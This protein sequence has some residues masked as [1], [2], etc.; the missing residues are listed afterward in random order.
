[1]SV[2]H[3]MYSD[4][5]IEVMSKALQRWW[6]ASGSGG[7]ASLPATEVFTTSFTNTDG[8]LHSPSHEDILDFIKLMDKYSETSKEGSK[9]ES[10]KVA[11]MEKVGT[12][13]ELAE[14]ITKNAHAAANSAVLTVGAPEQVSAVKSDGGK[15]VAHCIGGERFKLIGAAVKSKKSPAITL[16][17]RPVDAAHYAM[18]EMSEGNYRRIFGTQGIAVLDACVG[19][20]YKAAVSEIKSVKSK[21]K[22]VL[23]LKEKQ[24]VYKDIGYGSW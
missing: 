24:D 11:N 13:K 16:L 14:L 18:I 2:T 12:Y 7:G 23:A 10:G 6:Y 9:V 20:S 3:K 22:E 8:R 15:M 5:A 19:G 1:M 21:E 4:G 17:L